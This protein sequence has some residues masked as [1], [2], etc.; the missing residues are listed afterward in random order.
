M[1]SSKLYEAIIAMVAFLSFTIIHGVRLMSAVQD[2]AANVAA[3]VAANAALQ[4]TLT[5]VQAELASLK[6]DDPAV[7]QAN[8]DIQGVTSALV[9]SNTEFSQPVDSPAS[10]SQEDQLSQ[11]VDS[12]AAS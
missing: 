12:P 5:S 3:L 4:A 8:S 7:V 1:D 10:E 9:A 6:G 2:L 11:T